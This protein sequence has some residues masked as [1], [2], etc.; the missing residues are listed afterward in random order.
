MSSFWHPFADMA[1]RRDE[2]RDSSIVRGEGAYVWDDSGRRYLDATA[3]LWYC[4]VGL[5][6]P[7]DRR[8]RRPPRCET[9]PAYSTFGDLTN[10]PRRGLAE[11]VAGARAGRR[12]RRSSSPAA[13]PTRSTPPRR[14]PAGTG[15]SRG[16]PDRTVLIRREKA[17]H[18]MHT[19]GTS[20]AGIPANAVGPRRLIVDVVE[21]RGTTRSALRAAIERAGPGGSPRSSASR[22]RR[23]RRVPAAARLPRGGARGLPRDRR[24]VRRRRGDHRASVARGDWFASHA[25]RARPDIVTCAKGITSGYLPMGAVIAAPWVAE[26]FWARAPGCGATATPTAATRRWRPPRSRTSTSSSARTSAGEPSSSR[27]PL[28]EALLP[29]G[30]ARARRGGSGG[31]GRAGGGAPSPT[32]SPTTR[33]CRRRW[34]GVPRGR[35]AD[36]SARPARSRSRRRW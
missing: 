2:R 30:A 21:V 3:S 15:G 33:R 4:N 25:V 34:H 13:A 35:H 32:S 1:R 24:A 22:D 29:L 20:L 17:Y 23:G 18:G 31:I 8:C 9:L 12:I 7:R 14:W 36:A 5:G 16:Q 11:R 10:R 28:F 19:A 6:P 26:P 27:A